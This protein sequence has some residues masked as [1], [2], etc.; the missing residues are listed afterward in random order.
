MTDH[1]KR[2]NADRVSDDPR[3]IARRDRQHHLNLNR[4][5]TDAV[6]EPVPPA[7]PCSEY[8]GLFWSWVRILCN[9]ESV[10]LTADECAL[11][12]KL[13]LSRDSI[14]PRQAVKKIL[15]DRLGGIT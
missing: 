11:I 13:R 12:E 3:A 5:K 10:M 4:R 15:D 14:S 2:R 1:P 7:R 9:W 6:A 8:Q